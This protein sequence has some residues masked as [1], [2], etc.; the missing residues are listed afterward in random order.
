MTPTRLAAFVM[1]LS[2]LAGC[3]T[4]AARLPNRQ[5]D[6]PATLPLR[7][8]A[9][10]VGVSPGW[11]PGAGASEVGYSFDL[12]YAFTDRL[13]WALP[14]GMTYAIFDER[15]ADPSRSDRATLTVSTGLIGFAVGSPESGLFPLVSATVAKRL[16]RRWKASVGGSNVVALRVHPSA[17]IV[18]SAASLQATAALQIA[19]RVIGWGGAA[20]GVDHGRGLTVETLGILPAKIRKITTTPFLGV[21]V[22]PAWWL[23]LAAV[24]TLS[25]TDQRILGD[26]AVV[27]GDPEAGRWRSTFWSWGA[28]LSAGLRW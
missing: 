8:A 20:Q 7:T 28:T 3:R 6:D 2:L 22:R 17:A 26:Y 10:G 9:V 24:A 23:D 16:G 14:A 11:R 25:H 19:N 18:R 15:R 27:E 5:I 13:E 12:R 1:G 21:G 4:P